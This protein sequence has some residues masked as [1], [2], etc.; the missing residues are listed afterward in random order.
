MRPD[1]ALALWQFLAKRLK[2]QQKV[3]LLVVLESLG[4][5]PGRAGFK[6]AVDT[7]GA[8]CGSI[9]G[10]MME[11]KLVELAKARMT[12]GISSPLLKRQIHRKTEGQDQSG[13]ICSGEQSVVFL[14]LE[15]QHLLAI[16][17]VLRCLKQGKPAVLQISEQG[18]SIL[19]NQKNTQD[20]HFKRSPAFLYEENLGF[21]NRLYLIGGGHCALALSELLSK[22]DFYITLFDDRAE[23]NTFAKNRF[24]HQKQRVDH[25]EDIGEW[26]PPGENIYVIVM[27]VGYRTDAVV[28]RQLLPKKFRY[29]GVLGSAAKIETLLEQLRG[30]RFPEAQLA[31]LHTPIGLKINSRTP[32]EIA[33]SIAAEVIGVKNANIHREGQ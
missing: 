20:F 1:A 26:I 17:L 27:T 5:S 8:L 31:R 16:R 28:I 30:E 11:I 15:Q 25:Y 2:A 9:G 7:E 14:H 22:L 32:E 24:V 21:K 19:P 12:Q 6:M 29:F 3:A 33:V 18:L 4:S 13:M 23:L 10:G